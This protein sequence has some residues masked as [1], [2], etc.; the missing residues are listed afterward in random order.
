VTSDS[1]KAVS[2]FEIMNRTFMIDLSLIAFGGC[3][4]PPR[5]RE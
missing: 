1:Q 5:I 4:V 3:V 2:E